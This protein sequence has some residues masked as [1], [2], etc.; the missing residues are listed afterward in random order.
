M[1][2]YLLYGHQFPFGHEANL[3]PVVYV[4]FKKKVFTQFY[5]QAG[6]I[7]AV[8]SSEFVKIIFVVFFAFI[9]FGLI[10]Y[11]GISFYFNTTIRKS[12]K[13]LTNFQEVKKKLRKFSVSHKT[14]FFRSISF[15]L[16]NALISIYVISSIST[17]GKS[18][19]TPILMVFSANMA[20]YLIYYGT[21]KIVEIW[22][23]VEN[24]KS[25]TSPSSSGVGT[26]QESVK[27]RRTVRWFSL[28]LFLISI[29]T[30]S[31][32]FWFYLDKHQSRNMTPAESR[33]RNQL[34]G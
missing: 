24:R 2:F 19:S 20:I 7:Y 33:E 3:R 6:S 32:A 17:R 5:S 26:Q 25:P 14:R 18:L 31:I 28:I 8:D 22:E 9:Y 11:I 29:L 1:F 12:W 21:R 27:L 15:V 10:V 30:G 23:N 4:A 16:L 13:L 34:C